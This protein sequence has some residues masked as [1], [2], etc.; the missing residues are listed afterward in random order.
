MEDARAPSVGAKLPLDAI[1]AVPVMTTGAAYDLVQGLGGKGSLHAKPSEAKLFYG[2]ARD[3]I[4][5]MA[6]TL[7]RSNRS[8]LKSSSYQID[9][10]SLACSSRTEEK[11]DRNDQIGPP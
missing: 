5:T 3:P 9:R 4:G 10:P 2:K 6:A 11:L 7:I 1:L 8:S